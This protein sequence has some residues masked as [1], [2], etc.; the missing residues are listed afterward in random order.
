MLKILKNKYILLII[1]KI[2]IYLV[3]TSD[4][5][6]TLNVHDGMGDAAIWVLISAVGAASSM[7]IMYYIWKVDLVTN[8][9]ALAKNWIEYHE[10]IEKDEEIKPSKFLKLQNEANFFPI[11]SYIYSR[12]GILSVCT[13]VLIFSISYGV[14]SLDDYMEHVQIYRKWNGILNDGKIPEIKEWKEDGNQ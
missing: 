7:I 9:V 3:K 8:G 13:V 5:T 11:N 12:A 4:Y 1:T 14:I 6:F 10:I 2:S